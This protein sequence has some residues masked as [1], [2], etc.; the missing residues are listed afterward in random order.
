M[1]ELFDSDGEAKKQ[2]KGLRFW[3]LFVIIFGLVFVSFIYRIGGWVSLSEA[4]EQLLVELFFVIGFWIYHAKQ[5]KLPFLKVLF[6]A[7]AFIIVVY[8]ALL[9][10]I[11]AH[12]AYSNPEDTFRE[13]M[14]LRWRFFLYFLRRVL[15][16][17]AVEIASAIVPIFLGWW[18]WPKILAGRET[19]STNDME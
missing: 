12:P 14:E 18:L 19:N 17:F 4:N 8:L 13:S 2:R 9:I 6:G 11:F 5:K 7:Q 3:I 1:H 15:L 10:L 16:F